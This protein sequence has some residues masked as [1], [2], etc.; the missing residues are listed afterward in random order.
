MDS[1]GYA[2][3]FFGLTFE[4]E[5]VAYNE[6]KGCFIEIVVSINYAV[7][8]VM[9]FFLTLNFTSCGMRLCMHRILLSISVQKGCH[10]FLFNA[11]DFVFFF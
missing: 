8:V 4:R 3:G 6:L 1:A 10:I 5:M 7:L 11:L 9:A 2:N